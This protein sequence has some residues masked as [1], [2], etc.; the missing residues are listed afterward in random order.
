ML[1]LMGD[2]QYRSVLRN[3]LDQVE[4][5]I[6][7]ITL[8]VGRG[9]INHQQSGLRQ[10]LTQDGDD[11][12]L[13]QRQLHRWDIQHQYQIREATGLQLIDHPVAPLH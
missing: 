13:H 3:L 2:H 8:E 5:Q 6:G 7:F 12:L 10:G 11:A 1:L 4:Q 9:F